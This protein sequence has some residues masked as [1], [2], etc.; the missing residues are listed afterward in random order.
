MNV[1][2]ILTKHNLDM[3]IK[4]AAVFIYDITYGPGVSLKSNPMLMF[5][6]DSLVST[7]IN[8]KT[9]GSGFRTIEAYR[10]PG[11]YVNINYILLFDQ[12]TV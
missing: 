4:S 3:I 7:L 10:K 11:V 2:P 5:F 8:T 6:M 9:Y 1:Q 12:A